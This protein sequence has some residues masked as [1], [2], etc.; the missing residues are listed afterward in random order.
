MNW[1]ILCG[2]IFC[3]FK[4]WFYVY[5]TNFSQQ[6]RNSCDLRAYFTKW[7]ILQISCDN[8]IKTQNI[9]WTLKKDITEVV[10]TP[11]MFKNPTKI[12]ISISCLFPR[13]Q[14]SLLHFCT[15]HVFT[16]RQQIYIEYAFAHVLAQHCWVHIWHMCK[17]TALKSIE[18]YI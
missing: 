13:F 16:T 9:V 12:A 17:Y 3:A 14:N 8:R 15:A 2:S 7:E 10:T 5:C 11:Q 18:S 6:C 4:Q 1:C